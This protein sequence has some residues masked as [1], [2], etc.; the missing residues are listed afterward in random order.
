MKSP[1]T[2]ESRIARAQFQ[3][4]RSCDQIILI[5]QAL[6]SL[7]FRYRKAKA[8]NT[9]SFRYPLRL[10]LAVVEGIRNMY[11]DYAKQKADEVQNLRDGLLENTRSEAEAE[12]HD[13]ADNWLGS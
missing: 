10:R 2:I 3:F 7:S 6:G 13:M 1:I 9:R 5:N 11:Y 4:R 12:A 8:T